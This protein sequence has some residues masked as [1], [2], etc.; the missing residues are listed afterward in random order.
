MMKGWAKERGRRY[1]AP[2][3]NQLQEQVLF[4]V[5]LSVMVKVIP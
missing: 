3:Y 4:K 1:T 2:F 5:F